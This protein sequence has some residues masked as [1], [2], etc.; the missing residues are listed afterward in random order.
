MHV[1]EL[2]HVNPLK[3][4]PSGGTAAT[5]QLAPPSLLTSMSFCCAGSEF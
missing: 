2:G 5:R 1:V 3:Y 4:T